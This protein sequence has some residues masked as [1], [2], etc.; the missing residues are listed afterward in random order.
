VTRQLNFAPHLPAAWN[1]VT[2]KRIRVG[3][4]RIALELTQSPGEVALHINNEGAP[5]RMSFDPELP[6]GA[7]VRSARL[8]EREI[9][10]TREQHPQDS[11]ARI[12]FDLPSGET[13]LRISYSGGVAILPATPRPVVGEASRAMK[14]VGVSLKDRVYEMEID[15]RASEPTRVELRTPWKIENVRGAKLTALTPSSHTLEIDA[16]ADNE[17]RAYQRSKVIVTFVSVE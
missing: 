2:L 8:G 3:D 11:H 9:A 7:K 13:V 1:K 4:S 6:L 17:N 15:H 10:A 5:V 16:S 14:V 12:E